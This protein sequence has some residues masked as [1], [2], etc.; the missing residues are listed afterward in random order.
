MLNGDDDPVDIQIYDVEKCFGALWLED[1]ML[2]LYETLPPEARDDELSLLY[3]INQDNYV[4]VNTAVGQ[5]ERVNMKNIVMQGGK[6]G[7]LKCSNTMDKIGKKCVSKGNY[8]YTYK[9]RTKIMP[10]AMVDDLLAIAKCGKD[11][12]DIN[13]FINT[14]IEMKKL[15]FHIPDTNGKSK[16]NKIH[17]GKRQMDCQ[18]LKVHGCPMTEV[19]SDTYLGDIISRDGK[20]TLNIDKRVGKGLGIVSQIMD[21]LKNVSFGIHY[22]EI[23]ATLRESMLVNG[24][25]TNSEIWYGLSE[26]EVKRLEEVDRLLLRQIFQVASTCP[27]EALYLEL[28]CIPLGC[29]IKGRRIKYLHHLT[30]VD[31]NEM[32]SKFFYTQWK[33]PGAKNEWTE[34]VK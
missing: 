25:L 7:P 33:Y 17:I 29:I 4:A 2:D 6:W 5:T 22:F 18:G 1:C 26:N 23:G 19:S 9:R 32:L 28:G 31:E 3:K 10:L 20:N 11:S 24:L 27:T 16:C 34:Q 30:T 14:E 13:I 21:I 12:H 15:R 8:L